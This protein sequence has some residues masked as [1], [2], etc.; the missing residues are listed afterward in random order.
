MEEI[1]AMQYLVVYSKFSIVN[2]VN[3]YNNRGGKTSKRTYRDGE[4][5]GV[6]IIFNLGKEWQYQTCGTRCILISGRLY[7]G[8]HLTQVNNCI[9]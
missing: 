4:N 3:F 5:Q 7:I 6:E 9:K 8:G 1:D 2:R